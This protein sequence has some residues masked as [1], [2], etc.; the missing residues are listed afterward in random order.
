MK[1]SIVKIMLFAGVI[2]VVS[3]FSAIKGDS[4]KN[5]HHLKTFLRQKPIKSVLDYRI[6]MVLKHFQ[7]VMILEIL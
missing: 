6:R 7:E 4:E 2:A 3:S 1:K 5:I